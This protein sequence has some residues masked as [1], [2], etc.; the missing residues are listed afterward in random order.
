MEDLLLCET[1]E[2]EE[3]VDISN[4]LNWQ[5]HHGEQNRLRN[6]HFQAHSTLVIEAL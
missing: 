2:R 3:S 5:D 4:A 6:F 1:C